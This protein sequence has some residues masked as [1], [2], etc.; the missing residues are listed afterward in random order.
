MSSSCPSF[1]VS[2]TPDSDGDC[3]CPDSST[4]ADGSSGCRYSG[5]SRSTRY[6]SSSC[7]S[8]RCKTG[9]SQTRAPTRGDCHSS[10][11]SSRPDNDGDCKCASNQPCHQGGSSGCRYSGGS[12]ST[13][14]FSSTCSNCRCQRQ[15][16]RGGRS[17]SFAQ[18]SA[19]DSD[20]DCKCSTGA[21]CYSGGSTG[22]RYSRGSSSESYFLPSCT[23]C[24]CQSR[25]SSCPSFAASSTPDSDGDCKCPDSS[26]CRQGGSSQCVY[27]RSGR[28]STYFKSTCTNCRCR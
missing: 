22:C 25:S 26:T 20:G 24:R 8:C 27:S 15:T 6:F 3:K 10:A 18:S 17:P 16:S 21:K 5:S 23:D 12:S 1:A 2:S 28:S 11:V 13:T 7:T 14:Y 9:A 4:C 19:P